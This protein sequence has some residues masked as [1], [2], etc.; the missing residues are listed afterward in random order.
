M[1]K[2]EKILALIPARGGSKRLPEKNIK[3]L[4]GKPLIAWSID[5]AKKSKYIDR[6][7]V[8]TDSL[9]IAKV[10]KE[11][12][13]DVPFMRPCNLATDIAT[14]VDVV[15]HC[16][17]WIKENEG[18]EYDYVMLLQPTSPLRD[19]THIDESIKKFFSDPKTLSLVSIT[20]V[21]KNP[22]WMKII[23][24]D[25][26]LDDFIKDG[27]ACSK[28]QNVSDVF[29]LNGAIYI[30]K[31]RE[32]RLYKSFIT[33]YTSYYEMNEERSIDIDDQY[34]FSFAASIMEGLLKR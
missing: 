26:F 1:F 19:E 34:D 7:I 23:R 9:E 27:K 28:G 14:S 22:R 2:N 3:L 29:V 13:A 6:V 32:M 11:C 31:S 5:H 10:S 21:K 24:G 12:G 16:L 15:I 20:K 33:P 25:G 4:G 17:D 18:I 8:S 30:A